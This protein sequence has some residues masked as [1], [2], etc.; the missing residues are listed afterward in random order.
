MS[1]KTRLQTRLLDAVIGLVVRIKPLARLINRIAI[2][3]LCS[4]M[5]P[6]PNPLSTK[7]PYTSWTSLTDRTWSGRHL[8]PVPADA[9]SP[10]TTSQGP[11]TVDA[12]AALFVRDGEMIPC[13]KSTVL[14]TYFAQWFTDGFLRTD[15]SAA[16]GVLRNTRKNESNHEIDLAQLYGLNSAMTDQLRADDGLLKSQ[17][18]EGEEYPEFLY[19]QGALK[20]EFDKLL[21]PF[22]ADGLM[23]DQKNALFAMGSDTRNMGFMAFNV[24]FLREHNRIARLLK[25]TYPGWSND[26]VFETTRNILTVV[27]LKI[28]V[29]EYINHIT[30]IPFRFILSADGFAKE[31][32]FR[33]NWMAIEFNLLYRWHPLVPS[34]FTLN[35]TALT[36]NQTLSN[37]QALTSAGLGRFMADAS[38]QPAG[39]VGLFNT[40]SA[41]VA[42]ADR[43]SI[44]QG[45]VAQLRS[46][47]DYRVLCGQS[48]LKSFR[49]LNPDPTIEA[50]LS[51]VYDSVDD[52]EFYVGLFAEKSGVNDV[53]PP[54]T[55]L[56]V[57]FDA[58]SQALPNPLVSPRIFNETTF[59]A[60]GWEIVNDDQRISDI[61]H[62]NVPEPSRPSFVSL[63]RQG[64]RRV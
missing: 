43:P 50:G 17:M 24:L 10:P 39:R 64:Y 32:W 20:P 4:R 15:R 29:E 19:H 41:L 54:L 33:T 5:P 51:A 55:L 45:R 49:E 9:S 61:V 35:G 22:G 63:T 56:M 21:S 59:S 52:V 8:P 7:D 6:R 48:R 57:A 34:T 58:F 47:N 2:K 16:P 28:V 53:L 60:V 12:V 13:P 1:R 42:V 40:D 46:Y 25:Q 18:I 30:P 62:R 27:L 31:L 11:P 37:T 38:A 26:Q 14:F 3:R 44:E 36:I 23:H